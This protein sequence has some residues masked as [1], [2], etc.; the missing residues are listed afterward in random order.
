MDGFDLVEEFLDMWPKA[1]EFDSDLGRHGVSE[2]RLA[3]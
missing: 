3:V 2:S 1:L